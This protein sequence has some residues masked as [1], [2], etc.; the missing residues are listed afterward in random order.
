MKNYD[1]EVAIIR[2]LYNRAWERNWGDVPMTDEEFAYVAK[3]LKPIV[4]PH[5][6]IIAESKGRPVGFG[7]SL[8]DLNMVLKENKKGHL[9]PGLVRLL[10]FKKKIDFARI[11]ILGVVPEYLNTGIGGVLFYETAR[12]AVEH[13]Y[14]HGEAS[15]V[16]EDNLMMNRGAELLRGER[17]KTY[18]LFQMPL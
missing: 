16:L 4:D 3:D 8:P 9:I 14:F 18:R 13:G 7:L 12:R 10:L 6:V 17:T 11:V 5:L 15:W 2:D 1:N